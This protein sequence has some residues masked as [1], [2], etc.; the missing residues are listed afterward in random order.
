MR[1]T[2]LQFRS[3]LEK[4]PEFRI[5]TMTKDGLN[6]NYDKNNNG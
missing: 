6:L 5:T 2:N 3:P 4:A 1:H